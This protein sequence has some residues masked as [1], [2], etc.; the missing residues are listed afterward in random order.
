MLFKEDCFGVTISKEKELYAKDLRIL[1]GPG[2]GRNLKDIIVVDNLISN[3]MVHLANCIP[4]KDFE[5]FEDDTLVLKSLTKYLLSLKAEENVA[6]KITN[7]FYN[8]LF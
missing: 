4:I 8:K 1:L 7:D 2:S 3:F 6:H 5:G